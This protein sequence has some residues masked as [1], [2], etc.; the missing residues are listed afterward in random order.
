MHTVTLTQIELIQL[1]KALREVPWLQILWEK[2]AAAAAKGRAECRTG[3]T[4]TTQPARGA[5]SRWR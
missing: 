4:E 2:L 5:A 1:E 3:A